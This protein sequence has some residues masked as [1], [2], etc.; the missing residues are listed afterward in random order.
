MRTVVATACGMLL[1]VMLAGCVTVPPEEAAWRQM[2][3]D[4]ANQCK[5]RF[6]TILSVDRV[7]NFGRVNFTHAGA[8]PENV[9]FLTC[10]N[11]SVQQ[12]SAVLPIA[13]GRIRSAGAPLDGKTSVVIGV[14]GS[15][16]LVPAN[17][18]DRH[19]A[20]LLLDTGASATVLSPA[21]LRHIG[22]AVPLTAPRRLVTVVGGRVL[23]MP[24]VRVD[25]ISI[26]AFTVEEV[27]VLAYDAL[28]A[29]PDVHGILGTNVLNH[30]RVSIDR[31]SRRLTLERAG[32]A[33]VPSP[34]E[35][36][37]TAV[38]SR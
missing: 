2:L 10:Y 21:L 15:A 24:V 1:V 31:V 4:A 27:E 8:G 7:D 30:F 25:S 18:N 26:G 16:M 9:A 33:A 17:V 23:A 3:L 22:V 20:T 36:A 32:G 38:R 34:N 5:R 14:A 29:T 13:S 11:Q 28:P 37:P 35:D 12:Q 6:P 19:R